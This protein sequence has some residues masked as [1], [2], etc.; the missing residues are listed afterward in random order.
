VFFS[1][2]WSII[3][4]TKGTLLLLLWISSGRFSPTVFDA[5]AL[6]SITAPPPAIVVLRTE[7]GDICSK[8]CSI[9]ATK[10]WPS[11]SAFWIRRLTRS[12]AAAS[13]ASAAAA[14]AAT[15]E[16][17]AAAIETAAS[18]APIGVVI[19]MVVAEWAVADE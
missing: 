9:D 16:A 17:I 8:D 18:W 10:F 1:P 7:A 12:S 4:V 14:A 3:T 13:A 5:P 2:S 19:D 6:W 11:A 15:A